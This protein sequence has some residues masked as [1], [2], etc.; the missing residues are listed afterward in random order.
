VII[1]DVML[2]FPYLFVDVENPMV[3]PEM[4]SPQ[5]RRELEGAEVGLVLFSRYSVAYSS[6][7]QEMDDLERRIKR[8]ATEADTQKW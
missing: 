4:I 8:E 7:E 1:F 6:I 2:R 5:L 3:I